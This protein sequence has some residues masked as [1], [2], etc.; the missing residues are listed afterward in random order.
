M[1]LMVIWMVLLLALAFSV[2]AATPAPEIPPEAPG[3]ARIQRVSAHP[4]T[5]RRK[6]HRARHH[7]PHRHGPGA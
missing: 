6:A 5:H 1:K 3:A 7:R 2:Q 4:R